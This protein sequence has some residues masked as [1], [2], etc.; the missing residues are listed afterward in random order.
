MGGNFCRRKNTGGR[1]LENV[2]HDEL[3]AGDNYE[4]TTLRRSKTE[5]AVVHRRVDALDP[6]RGNQAAHPRSTPGVRGRRASP[7]YRSQAEAGFVGSRNSI[8]Y[9][10]LNWAQSSQ[11]NLEIT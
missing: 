3:F 5:G 8:E 10:W 4:N 2:R 9:Y 6:F 7:N 1:K 11:D